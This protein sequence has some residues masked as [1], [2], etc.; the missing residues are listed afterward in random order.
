MTL[1]KFFNFAI[2]AIFL[3]GCAGSTNTT[4]NYPYKVNTKPYTVNGKTYYPMS[5]AVGFSETGEASWYGPSFHGKKTASG[6]TYNQYAY[7]AAHK[8]LPFGTRVR[9]TNLNNGLSTVVVINDRGPFKTGRII[10]LSNAAAKKI[11]MI[12]TGTARVRITAIGTATSTS[13]DNVSNKKS[14]DIASNIDK[15]ATA[16]TATTTSSYGTYTGQNTSKTAGNYYV[17]I[18]LYSVKENADNTAKNLSTKGYA[19]A[20]KERNGGYAVMAGP[21]STRASAEAA[22]DNLNA[23]YNGAFIVQ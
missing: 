1:R 2:L 8:T 18:G 14:Y 13:L 20:V 5:S 21:Y 11:S 19:Y 7:T 9:V 4:S 3:S 10:D 23:T 16:A 17:Q 12:G 15:K 22:R 6:E